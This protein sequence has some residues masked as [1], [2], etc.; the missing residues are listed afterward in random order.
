VRCKQT[1]DHAIA[2]VD[3]VFLLRPELAGY[4]DFVIWVAND[5]ETMIARARRRDVAWIGPADAVE[6]RYR[7]RW[8]PTHE[9][10]EGLAHPV[11]RAG[12]IIDNRDFTAPRLLRLP[13]R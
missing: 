4:W 6:E 1:G 11:L 13:G 5:F 12:A 10:R 3:G 2:D 7:Q 8:I 9:L